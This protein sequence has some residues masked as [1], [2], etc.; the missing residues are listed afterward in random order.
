MRNN[1]FIIIHDC[2][3]LFSLMQLGVKCGDEIRVTADGTDEEAA[4]S[5]L[6]QTFRQ[7]GL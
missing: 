2:R 1:P 3:K 7:A 6:E 4:I 5:E